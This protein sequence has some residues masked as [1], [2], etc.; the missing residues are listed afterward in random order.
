MLTHDIIKAPAA[1]N[2][3]P[4]STYILQWAMEKAVVVISCSTKP[5]HLG[6]NLAGKNINI[7]PDTIPFV[8]RLDGEFGN[9][10][11]NGWQQEN[12]DDLVSFEKPKDEL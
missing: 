7:H 2:D 4:A 10:E 6:R 12:F 9:P 5:I 8:N 11:E 1:E 3:I